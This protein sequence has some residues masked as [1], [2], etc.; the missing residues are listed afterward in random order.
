MALIFKFISVDRLQV[1]L[2]LCKAAQASQIILNICRS[3][4]SR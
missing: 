3:A 4:F 2:S 1:N